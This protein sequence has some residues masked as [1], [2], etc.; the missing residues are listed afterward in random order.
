[1]IQIY[2]GSTLV[3]TAIE[4]VSNLLIMPLS[5]IKGEPNLEVTVVHDE[6]LK[7]EERELEE[8][9]DWCFINFSNKKLEFLVSYVTNETEKL[10]N[11]GENEDKEE[12]G[13]ITHEKSLN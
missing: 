1:M 8:E 4:R 12:K 2:N 5:K 3:D 11:E 7:T 9:F 6:N 10:L 13:N